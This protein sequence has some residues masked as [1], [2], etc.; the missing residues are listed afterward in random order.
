MTDAPAGSAPGPQESAARAAPDP[1]EPPHWLSRVVLVGFMAA[2]K[3]TVGEALARLWGW[4]F[5][6]FDVEIEHRAGCSVAEFFSRYG[7]AEFRAVEAALTRELGLHAD[8]VMAPGG[9]W[10]TQPE[11]LE[12]IGPDSLVVWL[13]ITPEQAVHRAERAP[14]HRPLLAGPDPLGRARAMIREREPLYRLADVAVMVDDRSPED[15][16]WEIAERAQKA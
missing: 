7:E 3:S 11:L 10:I 15:I 4:D 12:L 16:A 1:S 2:G 14:H 6:D 8:V 5:V 9:G 13:R